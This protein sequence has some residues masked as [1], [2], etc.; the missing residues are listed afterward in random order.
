MQQH[1]ALQG[2]P[3]YTAPS[4]DFRTVDPGAL[5]HPGQVP[6]EIMDFINQLI[7]AAGKG[8][9]VGTGGSSQQS[10]SS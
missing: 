1:A 2:R 6:S 5:E 9:V 10:S 8:G 7:G 4:R 3:T